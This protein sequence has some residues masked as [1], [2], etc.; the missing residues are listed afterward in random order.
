VAEQATNDARKTHQK[1]VAIVARKG[2][3]IDAEGLN[4]VGQSEDLKLDDGPAAA[5]MPKAKVD[6]AEKRRFEHASL[7]G[8]K[9]ERWVQAESASA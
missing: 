3:R 7:H 8:A 9:S 5:G 2:Q 4:E 6:R 1:E